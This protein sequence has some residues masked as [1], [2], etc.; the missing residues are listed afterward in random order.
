MLKFKIIAKRKKHYETN[1]NKRQ[2]GENV[3]HRKEERKLLSGVEHHFVPRGKFNT[4][5]LDKGHF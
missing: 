1:K 4:L 5:F 2:I 3:S